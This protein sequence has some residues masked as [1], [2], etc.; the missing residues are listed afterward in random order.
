MNQIR[1][2]LSMI[3]EI[4]LLAPNNKLAQNCAQD[5]FSPSAEASLRDLALD[6]G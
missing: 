4:R 6:R 1:R 3:H 2:F 5:A